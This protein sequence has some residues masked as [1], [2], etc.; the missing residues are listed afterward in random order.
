MKISMFLALLLTAV[1]ILIP[2]L[3]LVG[4]EGLGDK[5]ETLAVETPAGENPDAVNPA[6]ENPDAKN[7]GAQTQARENPDAETPASETTAVEH[8][9]VEHP[10]GT[11]AAKT[12]TTAS[13]NSGA[14]TLGTV[15]AVLRYEETDPRL[16]WGGN[17]KSVMGN[18]YSGGTLLFANTAGASVTIK[19][20]GTSLTWI[21]STAPALGLAKVTLDGGIPIQVD[22]HSPADHQGMQL[23]QSGNLAWGSHTVKI[24]CSWTASPSGSGNGLTVDAFDATG[25]LE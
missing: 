8:P 3:V 17:W 5:G 2:V 10:G 19:F 14:Q 23:W 13:W 20:L 11:P 1:V 16:V 9:A 24:E 15:A 21:G 4:C 6:G 7:P 25:T 12:T 22:C 18:S